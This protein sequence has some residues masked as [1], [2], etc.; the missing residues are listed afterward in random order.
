MMP[1]PD[2]GPVMPE[3]L[4]A[5]LALVVMM[6]DLFIRRKQTIAVISVVVALVVAY[7]LCGSE[8]VTFGGMF[9]SDGYSM[10]FKAVFLISLVL[11]ILISIT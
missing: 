8:G 11:S 3:I 5:C 7:S 4:L 1:F 2:L 6:F 10:F 9:I